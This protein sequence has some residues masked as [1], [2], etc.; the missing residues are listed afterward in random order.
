[1]LQRQAVAHGTKVPRSAA[2]ELPRATNAGT[3]RAAASRRVIRQ[4]MLRV[5]RLDRSVYAEVERD[6]AGTRQAAT[7]VGFVAAAAAVGTVLADSWHLGAILGAVLAALVHWLFWSG[8]EHLIGVALFHTRLSFAREA[9]ALGYAQTP[10]LLAILAFVPTVG[11]WIVAGSRLLAMVAGNQAI[12]TSAGLRRHQAIAIR[13]VS[14]L[15]AFLA[16]A[17]VRAVLGDV[18]FLTALLRP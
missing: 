14:F 8:L 7:V 6:P 13:V 12:S 11:V 5:L 16:G 9:R 17:G 4:R 3:E 10:E 18:G 15:I 2:T 1:M